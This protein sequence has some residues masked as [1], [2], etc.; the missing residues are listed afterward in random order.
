MKFGYLILTLLIFFGCGKSKYPG[1][2]KNKYGIY[3]KLYR[4]G[5]NRQTPHI[6]DYITVSLAYET[7]DDSVFFRGERTLQLSKSTFDGS[8]DLCFKS[9]A[10]GDSASFII[11]ADDFF[12]K[13]LETSLPTFIKKN[14]KIKVGIYTKMIRD[15]NQYKKEKEEF[16]A[17]IKDFGDYEKTVLKHFIE[18]EKINIKPTKSGMYF[19]PLKKGHGRKVKKGDVIT[20]NYEGKFL[21][22]NFFDSTLKRKE[23]F[24]F[25]YGT[26]WQVIK[27]L[28]EAIGMMNEGEKAL[29]IL[30][31]GLAWGSKG[32]TAGIVPPFTSVIYQIELIKIKTNKE[33]L[34]S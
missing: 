26:E 17:W 21:N 24:E 9:L 30:P 3:Y 4:F 10:E 28:D 29:V 2:T 16:L 33:S 18:E 8:I 31:S 22:G 1:Y 7:M 27:G 20:I 25:V 15:A 32:S 5:D 6:G 23:P 12:N 13:T 11:S 19:I 14:S 34:E